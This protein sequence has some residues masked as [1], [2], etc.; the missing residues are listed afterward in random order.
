[1]R[2]NKVPATILSRKTMVMS[3]DLNTYS[4][5]EPKEKADLGIKHRKACLIK[6]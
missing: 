2:V 1:M 5:K 6:C 3:R 4:P